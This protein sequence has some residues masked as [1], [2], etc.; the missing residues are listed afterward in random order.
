MIKSE[1]KTIV[2]YLANH[3]G[4]LRELFAIQVENEL[5]EKEQLDNALKEYGR[6]IEGMLYDH[7]ILKIQNENFV[8]NEPYFKLF[9]FILQ[10]FKPLLPEEISKYDTSI[11]TLFLKLKENIEGDKNL[12]LNQLSALSKEI[13]HFVNAVINN[14]LSL[15]NESRE[16]KANRA[17]IDYQEKVQQARFWIDHYIVPLNTILDS[18]HAQSIY[19]TLLDIARYANG[20][21]LDYSDESI[22]RQFEKLYNFLKQVEK[23]INQQSVLLTNE[24]LPLLERIKTESEILTGIS[25]YLSNGNCYKKIKPPKLLVTSRNV[26]YNPFVYEK[27]KEYFEHFKEE[28]EIVLIEQFVERK[29]WIFDKRLYKSKLDKSLP[30]ND[31]FG[32]CQ[33]CLEGSGNDLSS[34]N[35]FMLTSLIFEPD[36]KVQSTQEQRV[37]TLQQGKSTYLMP[38]LK[39]SKK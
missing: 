11:G 21:R 3:F 20:R 28:T 16:L 33:A 34:D 37:I 10:E 24:L 8:L 4:L 19:N 12:L 22:R 25:F 5:I 13:D 35:F 27:T 18:N 30:I 38:K 31:F 2:Q 15:L 26:V 39:I 29:E 7:K 32:W 9:E 1:P 14:T 17:K 23:D 36:Y 6:D